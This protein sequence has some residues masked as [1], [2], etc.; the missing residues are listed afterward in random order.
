MN[1]DMSHV[2]QKLYLANLDLQSNKIHTKVLIESER[3]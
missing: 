3:K 2:R 1:P